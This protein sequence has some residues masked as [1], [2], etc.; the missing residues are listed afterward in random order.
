[1][2]TTLTDVLLFANQ[3]PSSWFATS[4]ENQPHVRG[5]L[6][7]YADETGFYYHTSDAKRLYRQITSNPKVE[8]AFIRNANE[9][10]FETL[11]VTGIAEEVKDEAL[12]ER[13]YKE[14]PWLLENI[15]NSGF[16][17][18]CVI[19]RITRGSAY[20]WNM[21]WNIKEAQIPRVEF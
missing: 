17:S 7:W 11:H 15:K 2:S 13:L 8:V 18:N 6:L 12:K 21:S 10:S 16:K 3:N 20:I 19:F 5:M 1:M 14:R 4:E 9:P